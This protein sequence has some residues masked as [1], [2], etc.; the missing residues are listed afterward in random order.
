MFSKTWGLK[1][2]MIQWLYTAIIRPIVS[3]AALVWWPKTNQTAVQRTLN[4][5]QRQACLGITGAMPT[6]P[7]AAMEVLL[8]LSP[9]HIHVQRVAFLGAARLLRLGYIRPGSRVSHHRILEKDECGMALTISD[10]MIEKQNF[11]IPF[12]VV[13][14][15]RDHWKKGMPNFAPGSL[16]WYTDGS[17]MCGRSGIGIKGP[18]ASLVKS[19]GTNAT[20]FQAEVHAIQLCAEEMLNKHLNRAKVYILSDSQAALKAIASYT[21]NSKLVWECLN[22][23]KTVA[24]NNQVTLLWIPGHEGHEGNEIADNLAKRGSESLPIGPEPILGTTK[25]CLQNVVKNWEKNERVRYWQNLPGLR[26]AKLFL[27]F[28]KKRANE[29]IAMPKKDIRILVGLLTGHC[30][31]R[32]HLKKIGKLTTDICRFCDMETEDAEHIMCYC[33][34]LSRARFTTLGSDVLAPDTVSKVTYTDLLCFAKKWEE[35][36]FSKPFLVG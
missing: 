18:S 24:Q 2:R 26:Q 36:V 27:T 6:Y 12:K 15:D 4:K 3:Y 13:I 29:L 25:S 1:P 8:D 33:E 21:I 35:G 11:E 20:I 30:P 34:A 7:T 16:V 14:N 31:L 17:V 28:S 22:T 5:V 19:L 10:L 9:L 23:L 32:Y